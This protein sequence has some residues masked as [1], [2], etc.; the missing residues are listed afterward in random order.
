[1]IEL[2]IG[3]LISIIGFFAV[4]YIKKLIKIEENLQINQV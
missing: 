2:L 3:T 1:M 4:L